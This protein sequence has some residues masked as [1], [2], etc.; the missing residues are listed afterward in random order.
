MSAVVATVGGLQVVS[1]YMQGEATKKAANTSAAAS[2]YAADLQQQ[3]F[4]ITQQ[5]YRPYMDVAVGSPTYERLYSDTTSSEYQQALN[6]GEVDEQGYRI[7][8]NTG[9][10]AISGYS[11]GAL[12]ELAGYGQSRVRE[13]QYIPASDVPQYQ[14]YMGTLDQ[15]RSSIPEFNPNIDLQ[16]DQGYQFRRQEMQRQIDRAS[17]GQGKLLSG[18]RLEELI[19]RSGDLASQEYD[20]AYGRQLTGYEAARQREAS[21]YGRGADFY[22]QAAAREAEMRSRG[23]QDYSRQYAVEQDYLNYL[24]GLA[25]TGQQ[26]TGTV[27][28]IGAV[29]ASQQGQAIQ[30]AANAQAA[31]QIGQANAYANTI[32]NLTSLYGMTQ[33]SNPYVGSQGAGTYYSSGG[34]NTY[35]S[36]TQNLYG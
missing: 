26:A 36:P 13:G 24:R 6:R 22:T 5:N 16:N 15:A 23:I 30:N 25:G 27:A 14:T 1:G 10:R 12:Q 21:Q 9:Q 31:G 2:R 34:V 3:Q 32:G 28:Q 19:A 4:N 35:I 7:D 33:G 20:R 18:N 8:P 17:A 11:G 29:A